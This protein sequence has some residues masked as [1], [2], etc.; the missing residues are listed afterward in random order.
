LFS[1]TEALNCLRSVPFSAADAAELIETLR[2]TNAWV[3]AQAFYKAPIEP[4]QEIPAFDVNKTVA[5]IESRVKRGHYKNGYDFFRDIGLVQ[6]GFRDAHTSF[7]PACGDHMFRY[8]H[9]HCLVAVSDKAVGR[10]D[11]YT[12]KVNSSAEKPELDRQ[13]ATINGRPAEE[14]LLE[15]AS[16]HPDLARFQDPDA[17]FNMLF[18]NYPFKSGPGIFCRR[19]YFRGER[20]EKLELGFV[21]GEKVKAKWEAYFADF[22]AH[23]NSTEELTKNV[24]YLSAKEWAPLSPKFAGPLWKKDPSGSL[25]SRSSA[26]HAIDKRTAAPAPATTITGTPASA[27]DSPASSTGSHTPATRS[28]TRAAPTTSIAGY[29]TPIA[30]NEDDSLVWFADPDGTNETVVLRIPTFEIES[31]SRTWSLFLNSTLKRLHDS[32]AKR[33]IID[34]SGNRGGSAKLAKRFVRVLFPDLFDGKDAPDYHANMRYH[35]ALDKL[36]RASAPRSA[37]LE[38]TSLYTNL[39]GSDFASVDDVL[40][41]YRNA[42]VND[43]F[44]AM[45]LWRPD[46]DR[47]DFGSRSEWEKENVIVVSNGYCGS[48]CHNWMELMMRAG[49]RTYTFGGRANSTS[50]QPVGAT[51]SGIT[52]TFEELVRETWIALGDTTK[53]KDV[54]KFPRTRLLDTRVGVENMF[55]ASERD[56]RTAVPLFFVYT[57]GCRKLPLSKTTVHDPAAM[58]R[59][60]KKAAWTDD[61]KPRACDEPPTKSAK[62]PASTKSTKPPVRATPTKSATAGKAPRRRRW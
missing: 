61:G 19:Q 53:H 7:R 5:K 27:T 1:A 40:G 47:T 34:V 52:Y 12:V 44:T 3:A 37:S 43:S 32:S 18:N 14:F 20:D 4:L 13:V 56:S 6:T 10:R 28:A 54:V 30:R 29:P 26:A 51:K 39:N 8:T 17:R 33:L 58:W 46:L 2:L 25:W 23:F 62:P 41:P 16:T 45:S 59:V 36:W 9:K 57:P 15:M 49:I 35:S 31:D 22:V 55:R 38:E 24:C 60:A 50:M 48:T 11:I 21:G 42:A